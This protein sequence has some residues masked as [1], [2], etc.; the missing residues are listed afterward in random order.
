MGINFGLGGR[1][2]NRYGLGNLRVKD[3]LH[4]ERIGMSAYQKITRVA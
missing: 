3:M 4:V 2:T 1:C